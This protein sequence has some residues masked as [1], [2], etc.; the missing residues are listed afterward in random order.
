MNR[1]S[2]T[3]ILS[4]ATIL[5]VGCLIGNTF[6]SFLVRDDAQEFGV[7][8]IPSDDVKHTV[9][10]YGADDQVIS[11]S[12]VK[13]GECIDALPASPALTGYTFNNWA[14]DNT[15]FTT[16]SNSTILSTEVTTDMNYYAR[17][18]SYG[19]T[20]NS[21]DAI[22]L[23]NK[24]DLNNNITLNKDDIVNLGTYV[25]GKSQLE[26]T[27]SSPITLIHDG[28][29]ALVC[30]GHEAQWNKDNAKNVNKWFVEKYL[31]L[32]LGDRWKSNNSF[33]HFFSG[34]TV[35]GD[36]AMSSLGNGT[37]YC[38]GPYNANSVIF[39]L[40]SSG[41]MPDQEWHN[42]MYESKTISFDLN[43]VQMPKDA[44]GGW[45][46]SNGTF[47]KI[48]FSVPSGWSPA[49]TKPRLY[50]RCSTGEY[51]EN[52]IFNNGAESNMTSV[53][54]NKYYIEIDSS[55]PL[56]LLIII[57]NQG[58]SVK[59]SVDIETNLPSTAGEYTITSS[60]SSW[61]GNVFSGV[62]ISKNS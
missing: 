51:T 42:V 17:F 19:Y 4:L 62:S 28:D 34:E 52:S 6:A 57:F 54:G 44:F 32:S 24:W 16:V 49:P 26:D 21:G 18:A 11:T 45:D 20:V 46:P 8:I 56:S 55:L 10:F 61:N 25:Y 48:Y 9:T 22:H 33:A 43:S 53:S 5:T 23:P 36:K 41:N 29:Y 59:Q 31:I 14:S 13:D 39:G 2:K 47:F 50:Y 3:I 7:R 30:D 38:Y 15:S 58:D 35:L 37:S 27:I 1:T 60:Y 40:L 12:E